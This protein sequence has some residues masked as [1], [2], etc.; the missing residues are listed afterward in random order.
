MRG[1]TLS[2]DE[3]RRIALAAQG[4]ATPAATRAPTARTL[5]AAVGRLGAL[6][7]DSVN[8]LV[9]AHY[10]PLF[11]RLGSYPPEALDKLA[12]GPRRA[13]FEYWGH[14]ASLLPL[15][16]Y[17]LLRWRMERGA[18]GSGMYG[19]LARLARKKP[20]FI[21][22]IEQEVRDR[23][24]LTAGELDGASRATG[25]WW[26]WSEHKQALEFLFWS[27]RLTTA[28]RRNFER[29]YDVVDRVIPERVRAQPRLEPAAQQR[30]LLARA[31]SAAGVGT[32]GDLADY[33][34][35]SRTEARPRI[36]ELVEEGAL[37][38]VRVQGWK[39]QAYL[40]PNARLPKSVDAAA[41]VSPFD[42]LVWERARTERLFGFRYRIEIYTPAHKRVH[43]YYVLPF[44][45]G[46][47]LVARVDL[48]SDRATRALLMRGLHF[49]AG[50]RRRDVMP[51][52]DQTLARMAAWL[53]LDRVV[54][55][56]R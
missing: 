14:R 21:A 15:D 17:P 36:E 37:R 49:E 45:L 22:R 28:T 9:R 1:D 23:G 12:Y 4:F 50:V 3:A 16:A 8:V 7:I 48:K 26:G 38:E 35:L 25:G 39:Q 13:L 32:A 20:D 43:G 31:A 54:A 24:P 55:S 51:R 18:L 53:E 27:G 2:I 34:R 52:L 30:G 56:R 40:A 46:D 29:V 11:A 5:S 42:S 6:Q 10:L 33:F 47:R 19:S 41:L 44:L